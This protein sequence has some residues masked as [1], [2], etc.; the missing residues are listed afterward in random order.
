MEAF[1]IFKTDKG[2]HMSDSDDSKDK[3]APVNIFGKSK[4]PSRD[5][6]FLSRDLNTSL[7][8]KPR[9]T[10][11]YQTGG[12]NMNPTSSI[13]KLRKLKMPILRAHS[14][15]L[16]KQLA[17]KQQKAN[18]VSMASSSGEKAGNENQENND[19]NWV[20][21]TAEEG[22]GYHKQINQNKSN[23]QDIKS[24]MDETIKRVESAKRKMNQQ[25]R[26]QG[27][28]SVAPLME[29]V[30]EVSNSEDKSMTPDNQSTIKKARKTLNFE[31]G[32]SD[33][34]YLNL[35]DTPHSVETKNTTLNNEV[36]VSKYEQTSEASEEEK[37]QPKAKPRK[38]ATLKKA[39][40]SSQNFV[41]NDLKG[42]YRQKDRR[43]KTRCANQTN[44]RKKILNERY[45]DMNIKRMGGHGG[46]GSEGLDGAY[47]SEVGIQNKA[48]PMFSPKYTEEYVKPEAFPIPQTDEEYLNILKEQFG[49]DHFYEGQLEAI[50]SILEKEESCLAILS[51]GG[52]KS[53]IYQY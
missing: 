1:N 29:K 33:S 42:G 7:P 18:D 48:I 44:K 27:N 43:I 38:K 47:V 41:R 8:R 23:C 30:D 51:T 53:L 25:S 17:E 52:G 12:A 21:N 11:N 31:A 37:V 5:R 26:V 39:A 40:A 15:N 16:E 19:S 45:N 3:A 34:R 14:N 22:Q 32:N 4:T 28:K 49:F 10:S 35:G 36:K 50:K 13:K 6:N 2:G 46:F 24:T 9:N 20:D